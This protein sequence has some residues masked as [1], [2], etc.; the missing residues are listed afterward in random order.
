MASAKPVTRSK[1]VAPSPVVA[2][3]ATHI[4]VGASGSQGVAGRAKK[5]VAPVQKC[6]FLVSR[7]LVEA[8]S[9][10]SHESLPHDPLP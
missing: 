10:E 6:H 2:P 1:K 3:V 4:S 9:A 7:M 5:A 8:S